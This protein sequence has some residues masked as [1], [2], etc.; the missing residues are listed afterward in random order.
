[1]VVAR[2]EVAH[3]LLTACAVTCRGTAPT[4]AALRR[5]CNGGRRSGRADRLHG[6]EA[7]S[8]AQAAWAEVAHGRLA[9]EAGGGVRAAPEAAVGSDGRGQRKGASRAAD[10][11]EGAAVLG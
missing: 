10:G 3:G 5:A 11:G 7:R 8:Y 2:C 6:C 4:A 9:M 1:V